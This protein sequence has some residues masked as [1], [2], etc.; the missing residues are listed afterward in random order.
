MK[1][2]SVAAL[3]GC[4]AA[5]FLPGIAFAQGFGG[6]VAVAGDEKADL[7]G[8]LRAG[9]LIAVP[10][11]ARQGR[12]EEEERGDVQSGAHGMPPGWPERYDRGRQARR[13]PLTLAEAAPFVVRRLL[14]RS[15]GDASAALRPSL[16]DP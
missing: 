9:R 12:R 8:P 10:V 15:P 14:A 7:D 16:G 11:A 13:V 1:R 2:S 5:G 3:L 4:V 6:V